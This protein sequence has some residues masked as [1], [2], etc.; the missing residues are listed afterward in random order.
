MCTLAIPYWKLMTI[1]P[2]KGRRKKKKL[3]KDAE[4]SENYVFW[5]DSVRILDFV[6]KIVRF[7]PIELIFIE[8]Y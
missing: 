5:N 8:K 3:E 7:R 6:L 2:L 1:T 4:C